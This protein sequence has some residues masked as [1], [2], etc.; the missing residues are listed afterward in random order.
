MNANEDIV[1]YVDLG[2]STLRDETDSHFATI[3]RDGTILDRHEIKIGYIKNFTYF[4]LRMVSAYLMLL[5]KQFFNLF[6]NFQPIRDHKANESD[7]IDLPSLEE[8]D[9][10]NDE[11]YKDFKNENLLEIIHDNLIEIYYIKILFVGCPPPY[12][13][14]RKY[15]DEDSNQSF[16]ILNRK[17]IVNDMRKEIIHKIKIEIDVNITK[18]HVDSIYKRNK[19]QLDIYIHASE[20]IE[21]I[22]SQDIQ[23]YEIQDG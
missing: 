6:D 12:V 21:N 22:S 1:G 9:F 18:C 3:L 4:R 15:Y 19:D 14:L 20:E 13:S 16:V 10:P 2:K 5:D 8:D 23:V 7:L 11:Y 17:V